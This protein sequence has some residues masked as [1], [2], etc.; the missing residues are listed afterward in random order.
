MKTK[1][2][3]LEFGK[4]KYQ[5]LKTAVDELE[6]QLNLGKKEA[7]KVFEREK[8]RLSE[9]IKE[10]REKMDKAGDLAEDKRN[11]LV[12]R[13]EKLESKLEEK[14]EDSKEKFDDYKKEV[15]DRI[16][17]LEGSLQDAEKDFDTAFRKQLLKFKGT[18]DAYRVQ[19]ALASMEAREEVEEK[20]QELRTKVSEI[21]QK[22]QNREEAED[23]VKQFTKEMQES[24]NH[25][26]RA[27]TD[28]F[29]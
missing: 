13:F 16:H 26:K 1:D 10:Q 2:E 18:L 14:T 8:S 6:V 28:L 20:R 5:Q 4:E 22:L 12:D 21:K 19:V 15:M 23:R 9:F 25:M 29:G 11:E 24:F 7:E 3:I 27:F 17:E